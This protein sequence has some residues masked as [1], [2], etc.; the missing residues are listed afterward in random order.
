MTTVIVTVGPAFIG[1]LATYLNGLLL[2]AR[3]GSA[4][5]H[6]PAAE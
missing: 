6:Q 2:A 4:H 3:A 1:Y 5:A